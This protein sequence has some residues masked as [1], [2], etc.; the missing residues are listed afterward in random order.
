MSHVG[1][2]RRWSLVMLSLIISELTQK[3]GG[4]KKTA[5]LV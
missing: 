4:G 1:A 2:E 3:D 5:N